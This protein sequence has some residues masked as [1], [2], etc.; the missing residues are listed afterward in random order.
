M[1]IVGLMSGTSADG[2]D[3][4]VVQIEGAP[5]SLTW[6]VLGFHQQ[7]HSAELRQEIFACFQPETGSVDRLCALNFSI[8]EAFSKAALA[9]IEKASL[10]PD[11]VDIIGSHGQ[12]L[13]HIPLGNQASTLQLGEAAVIAERTGI[14]TIS[15]FRTRDMAA[16][17]QGAPLVAYVDDLLFSHPARH[18]A[19]QNIGGIGNVTFLPSLHTRPEWS[20]FAF[21][22]GPGNVLLDAA[23]VRL[24]QGKWTYDRNGEL[25]SQGQINT[26]LLELWLRE[27]AYFSQQPPKTTGRERFSKSYADRLCDQ[28]AQNHLP[29]QDL[30]ATLAAFTVESI[31]QAYRTFFPV[32]PD[33]VIVSGG[34]AANPVIMAG[35]KAAL[36]KAVIAPSDHWGLSSAEKEAVAFAVL[37]Y[38]TYHNRTG[39]LPAA[40]GARKNAVLG[41]LTPGNNFSR[42]YYGIK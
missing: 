29:P 13:W 24:T 14:T 12:T 23:A 1:I 31:A 26:P 7:A 30:M 22:T 28:A 20:P 25:A 3:A 32:L 39:N 40:T 4:A 33:E 36:P 18:R 9:V 27:E 21:D 15:N 10:S 38:E 5:P 17:G 16:G 37:A 42:L 2:I 19:C 35:L 6:K 11:D 41:T 8:A 34:G